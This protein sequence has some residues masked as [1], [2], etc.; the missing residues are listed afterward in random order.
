[1]LK[2]LA[3]ATLLLCLGCTAVPAASATE[4]KLLNPSF[5][6][7]ASGPRAPGWGPSQHFGPE[8]NYEWAVDTTTAAD[9]KSSYRIRRL[10]PQVFGLINQ[11]VQV[12]AYAGKTLEL[13]A[14]LKADE[15]G[16]EGWLLVVNIENRNAILEQVRSKPV[17][18]KQDWRRH[19]VRFKLPADVFELKIGVMLLDSGTGWVDD[20]KLRVVD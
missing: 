5:E 1:M 16:P 10:S 11:G 17:T 18:G 9:G 4:I 12:A 2:S 13:S 20:V 8:R 7:P 3:A 19:S 6:E 15:V 14:M